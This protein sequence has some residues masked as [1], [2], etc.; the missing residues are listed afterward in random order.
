MPVPASW[1]LSLS[2]LLFVIGAVGVLV[3]RNAIV[4]LMGIEV[5]LNA[6]NLALVLGARTWGLEDALIYTFLVMTVAAAEAAVGLALIIALF[7]RTKSLNL[8]D[9]KSL[10]G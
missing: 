2:V 5:M 6:G 8:D 9:L 1:Y 3:S 4:L 10:S 7:R